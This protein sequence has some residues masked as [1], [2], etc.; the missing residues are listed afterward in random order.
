MAVKSLSDLKRAFVDPNEG[1][2]PEV[3]EFNHKLQSY[4]A[5]TPAFSEITVI[6]L[7]KGQYDLSYNIAILAKK[8]GNVVVNFL[9]VYACTNKEAIMPREYSELI[10]R[11]VRAPIIPSNALNVR[12]G[13]AITTILK[14]KYGA[15]IK[16]VSIDGNIIWSNVDLSDDNNVR[17][18]GSLAANFINS[19]SAKYE[20]GWSEA[21]YGELLAHARTIKAYPTIINANDGYVINGMPQFVEYSI[22]MTAIDG[23][24]SDEINHEGTAVQIGK[25]VGNIQFLAG[26]SRNASIRTHADAKIS[27]AMKA[28]GKIVAHP[29]MVVNALEDAFITSLG[30]TLMTIAAAGAATAQGRW[31]EIALANAGVPGKNPGELELIINSLGN[32]EP[33]KIN[34][35]DESIPYEDRLDLLSNLAEGAPLLAFDITKFMSQSVHFTTLLRASKEAFGKGDPNK[36][37]LKELVKGAHEFT[38]GKFPLNF[39]ERKIFGR[40]SITMPT[41]YF[42]DGRRGERSLDEIDTLMVLKKFGVRDAIIKMRLDN[43]LFDKSMNSV[44]LYLKLMNK[45]SPDIKITGVKERV[46]LTSEFVLTLFRAIRECG[47]NLQIPAVEDMGGGLAMPDIT[48]FDSIGFSDNGFGGFIDDDFSGTAGFGFGDDFM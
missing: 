38:N 25:I 43:G 24:G 5:E 28:T 46:F 17:F 40:Q 26:S 48:S 22:T 21:Q 42:K 39:P 14:E 34:L 20:N 10:D 6:S 29:V 13:K 36:P 4:F 30:T 32:E 45:V 18:Y 23:D 8:V 27:R 3:E 33:K 12:A 44:D 31:K 41:G 16:V 15:D 1:R 37:Y 2:H 19:V 47:I 11:G 7:E 35:A 9:F